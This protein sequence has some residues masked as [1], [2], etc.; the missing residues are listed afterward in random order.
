MMA[1]YLFLRS[2]VVIQLFIDNLYHDC[3][4]GNVFLFFFIRK[5]T[6]SNHAVNVIFNCRNIYFLLYNPNLHNFC[7]SMLYLLFFF[8][9]DS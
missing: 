9:K 8:D 6:S 4:F 2:I 1:T 7:I 5:T 3:G